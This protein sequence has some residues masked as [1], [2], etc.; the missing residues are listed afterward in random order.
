MVKSIAVANFMEKVFNSL[1][2][3][4]GILYRAA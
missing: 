4:I 3:G 2:I 1:N